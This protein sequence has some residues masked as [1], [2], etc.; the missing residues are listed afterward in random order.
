[1]LDLLSCQ[2]HVITHPSTGPLL[3]RSGSSSPATAISS[4]FGH[5]PPTTFLLDMVSILFFLLKFVFV[6]FDFL[7]CCFF[8]LFR[9]TLWVM[10]LGFHSN[11]SLHLSAPSIS[12]ACSATYCPLLSF[13]SHPHRDEL[14]TPPSDFGFQQVRDRLF[15]PIAVIRLVCFY[16]VYFPAIL[17]GF[18]FWYNLCLVFVSL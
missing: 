7:F 17:A 10:I 16:V 8:C 18:S 3:L 13:F 6:S 12:S 9:Y 4:H 11:F 1:M 2:T 14:S 5:F 15:F